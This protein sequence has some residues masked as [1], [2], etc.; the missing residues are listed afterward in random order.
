MVC[1][2]FYSPFNVI[3]P[4][5][6]KSTSCTKKKFFC[7]FETNRS[8]KLQ[9]KS[10]DFP[11]AQKLFRKQSSAAHALSLQ[12]LCFFCSVRVKLC[13]QV[14]VKVLTS[15]NSNRQNCLKSRFFIALLFISLLTS[16]RWNSK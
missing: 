12:R 9:R 15:P 3:A 6:S 14:L 2:L 1:C 8:P 5:R 4:N 7:F 10:T 13:L 11:K 16:K